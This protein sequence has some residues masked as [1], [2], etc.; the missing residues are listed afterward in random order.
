MKILLY[1]HIYWLYA[2]FLLNNFRS[3]QK[4]VL[5]SWKHLLSR[6][7][8]IS[9]HSKL[10]VWRGHKFLCISMLSALMHFSYIQHLL[11]CS[12]KPFSQIPFSPTLSNSGLEKP[13][14]SPS[15]MG[16]LMQCANGS[17]NIGSNVFQMA[18]PN[19]GHT[20]NNSV[21]IFF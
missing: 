8:F 15:G 14:S 5:N 17:T 6:I 13:I 18:T 4:R 9:N 3:R 2:K 11:H 10:P 12:V 16:G 19:N 20:G 21:I 7:P 1:Q